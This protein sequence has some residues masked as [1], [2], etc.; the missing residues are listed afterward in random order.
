MYKNNFDNIINNIY[1]HIK[2]DEK[3]INHIYIN[4]IIWLNLYKHSLS[5]WP[6]FNEGILKNPGTKFI[7]NGYIK[8]KA[9]LIDESLIRCDWVLGYIQQKQAK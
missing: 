6:A 7:K 8:D 2:I 5:F 9:K 4:W 1:T 3:F